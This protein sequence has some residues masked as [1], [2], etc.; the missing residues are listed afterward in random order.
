MPSLLMFRHAKDPKS[1][2][3]WGKKQVAEI[4]IW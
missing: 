1:H 2:P 4:N 3:S